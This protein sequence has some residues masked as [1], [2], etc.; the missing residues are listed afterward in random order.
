MKVILLIFSTVINSR[1]LWILGVNH[2]TVSDNGCEQ[3]CLPEPTKGQCACA[4]GVIQKDGRSCAGEIV[5][6]AYKSN[7]SFDNFQ[8]IINMVIE[9][10]SYLLLTTTSSVMGIG[11][12]DS[13][14]FLK[15]MFKPILR[16]AGAVAIDY[17]RRKGNIYFTSASRRNIMEVSAFNRSIVRTVVGG[18]GVAGISVDWTSDFIYY[19]DSTYDVIAV[20]HISGTPK[21]AVL[22]TML[23]DPR[24]IAIDPNNA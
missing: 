19:T 22:E 8:M 24:S 9:S 21:L 14:N 7:I 23:D 20:V 18:V 16:Q 2:C 17:D 11:P 6:H 15:P 5:H 13:H 3:L 1:V 4:Y 10:D 12:H